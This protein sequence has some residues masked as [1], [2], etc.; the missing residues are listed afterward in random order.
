MS[1]SLVKR[2]MAVA[3]GLLAV[4]SLAAGCSSDSKTAEQKYCDSWQNVVNA[5]KGIENVT[6]TS[7]GIENLDTTVQNIDDAAR[8]LADSADSMAKPKVTAFEDSLKNL[9]DLVKSP[10]ISSSYLDKVKTAL[11]DVDAAW[12]DL[13][14]TI[15]TS[16]PD[17]KASSV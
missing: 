5:F 16:C 14:T 1:H 7:K 8:K 12:N 3:I 9:G 15:K 10:E 6:I 2:S 17:V 13:V 4:V 11:D